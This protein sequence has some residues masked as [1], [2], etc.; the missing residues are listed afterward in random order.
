MGTTEHA[1][2]ISKEGGSPQPRPAGGLEVSSQIPG[3]VRKLEEVGAVTLY[4]E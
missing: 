1:V 2:G 4:E 3:R